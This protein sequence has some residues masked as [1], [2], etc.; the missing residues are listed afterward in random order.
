MSNQLW[1]TLGLSW[2]YYTAAGIDFYSINPDPDGTVPDGTPA[3]EYC[4]RGDRTPADCYVRASTESHAS[5]ETFFAYAQTREWMGEDWQVADIYMPH[6]SA[7]TYEFVWVNTH[8]SEGRSIVSSDQARSLVGGG[9]DMLGSGCSV[10]RFS[11]RGLWPAPQGGSG[12]PR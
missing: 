6:I 12:R 8:A 4:L 10:G 1:A 3:S 2:D 11:Q 7:H 5:L 9:I